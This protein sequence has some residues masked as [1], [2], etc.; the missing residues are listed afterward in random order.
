MRILVT[1]ASG[2]I[3]S[4]LVPY[5]TTGGHTV[6]RLGRRGGDTDTVTWDPA[7]GSI[8]RAALEGLDAVVHLAGESVAGGRW[9]TEKKARIRD[10]RSDGTRVLA[11]ALAGLERPPKVLVS[12]S[13]IGIYG[14]R[15]GEVLREDSL[16]G[17]G[18][19]ADV[20]R[21]WEAATAP[22]A[23]RGIRVAHLRLGVV[24]SAAGGALATM[25][26]P[27]MLGAGGPVGDGRQFVSWVALDDVLD[28]ILFTLTTPTLAGPVNAVAPHP[29]TNQ[30]LAAILARVLGRPAFVPF[31]A[32]AVRL[33][34]GE[35]G[36]ELLLA[37]TRVE[38]GRLAAAG[39]AF[40]YAELEPALRHLLGRTNGS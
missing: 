7:A 35:M 11:A 39:F 14:D 27:F 37:S 36:D 30:D 25:L 13:A 33:L 26:P 6:I 17:A 20:C 1:G 10:S 32:A 15:G 29:V 24:L 23:A 2:L 16:P 19:L 8:D 40:R 12:A 22:A 9:T 38:P 34:L 5:L 28:A 3:G 18:F 4:S 31:P 21:A